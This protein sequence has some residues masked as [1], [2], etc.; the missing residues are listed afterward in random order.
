MKLEWIIAAVRER[1]PS[2]A[3]RV[4]GAAEFRPL[5]ETSALTV[6]CAY[7]IPLDDSPEENVSQNAIRQPL[8]D[9][10][11]VIVVVSNKADEKGQTSAGEIHDIRAELWGALLGWSPNERYDPITYDGGTLL[12]L[13]RARMFYQ[14]EFAAVMEIQPEDGWNEDHPP[15]EGATFNLN[16]IDPADPN[17]TDP[18]RPP[19]DD[20]VEATFTAP[21]HGDFPQ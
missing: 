12:S 18:D 2:F 20:R 9:A 5:Q 21:Q 19:M 1:C 14:F 6:P 16:S 13:D 10:F 7:V 17:R 3:G 8:N 11:A 15:F 4:G